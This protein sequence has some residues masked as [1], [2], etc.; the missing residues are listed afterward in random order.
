VVTPA[1]ERRAVAHLMETHGMAERG[2]PK[3]I[4]SDNVLCREA[5]LGFWPTGLIASAMRRRRH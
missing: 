3:M 1:A 5:A 2:K 4:V